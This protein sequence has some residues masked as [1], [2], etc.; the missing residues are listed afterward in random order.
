MKRLGKILSVLTVLSLLF[1]SAACGNTGGEEEVDLLKELT[2]IINLTQSMSTELSYTVKVN[3]ENDVSLSLKTFEFNGVKTVV[4]T[5][6][7]PDGQDM[8]LYF[9]GSYRCLSHLG[10][11]VVTPIKGMQNITGGLF[12]SSYLTLSE[13]L[14]NKVMKNAAVTAEEN[15]NTKRYVVRAEK[16]NLKTFYGTDTETELYGVETGTFTIEVWVD[17]STGLYTK[18]QISLKNTQGPSFET[19]QHAELV[20][21]GGQIEATVPEEVLNAIEEY[22]AANGK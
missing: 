1:I 12:Q 6:Y 9:M 8:E 2:G 19:T 5:I 11:E 18:F 22:K 17:I 15:G 4:E 7:M 21:R 16:V 14:A 13:S 10:I 3:E 20:A